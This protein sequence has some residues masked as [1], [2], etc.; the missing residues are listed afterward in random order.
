[1]AVI[2]SCASCGQHLT[3]QCEWGQASDYDGTC[4]DREPAVPKGL[5]VLLETESAV[6][7][8]RG[9][10]VVGRRV[11]SLAG[12]IA[13]NPDDVVPSS[14]RPAGVDNGC[15][16]SDGMDGPNRACACGAM[17]AIEWSDCW[18]QAEVRFVP[19]TVAV[20]ELS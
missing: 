4:V 20:S 9:D 8:F 1:M 5:L 19:D 14:L 2:V 15:C 10:V 6:D 7:V 3:S 18:T 11:Y 13:V 12:S 17:V 16:G